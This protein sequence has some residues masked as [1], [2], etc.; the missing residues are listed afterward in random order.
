M[1]ARVAGR[2]P[3]GNGGVAERELLAIFRFQVALGSHRQV[4]VRELLDEV[5]VPGVHKDA[6]TAILEHFRAADMVA[7]RMRDDH[8]LD[9]ACVEPEPLHPADDQLLGVV[10]VDRVD[11]NEA[12]AR[13][14]RPGRVDLATDE[15]QVV[16]DLRRIGVPYVASGHRAGV[17]D[18]VGRLVG[19]LVGFVTQQRHQAQPTQQANVFKSGRVLWPPA[20][21]RRIPRPSS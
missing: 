18:K 17:A 15:I 21:P 3:D 16:E 11:Q 20:G 13:L 10:R 14:Q 7:M 1:P 5:P 19:R 2:P 12:L 9:V 6:L 8:V 4:P